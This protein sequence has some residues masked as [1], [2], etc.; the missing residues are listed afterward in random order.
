MANPE[1]K[2]SMAVKSAAPEE[3]GPSKRRGPQTARRAT[4]QRL[5]ERI[6][7]DTDM[8]RGGS[9][10][11]MMRKQGYEELPLDEIQDRL[12]K[13]RTALAEFIVARRT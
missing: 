4:K 3:G 9:L 8:M 10:L 12:S 13:I 6:Q 2:K 11:P 1:K 7:Q 5:V